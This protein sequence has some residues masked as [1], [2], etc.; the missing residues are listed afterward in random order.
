MKH[1]VLTLVIASFNA[2]NRMDAADFIVPTD[3]QRTGAVGKID[4]L[5][6]PLKRAFA[7]D[8][9]LFA[10]IPAP[11]GND[12]LAQHLEQGQTYD[13]FTTSGP[14]RPTQRRST[15]YFLPVGDFAPETAPSLA[16]LS[17]FASA[18]FGMK[19]SILPFVPVEKVPARTRINSQTK[20]HQILSTDVLAWLLNQIPRD[21]FSVIAITMT[22]LYPKESWNF[23]F[24]QASL[25]DR[26]GVFSFARYD[27]TFYGQARDSGFQQLMLQRSA[28]VLAHETGHMFGIKHCIYFR[29]LMNGANH[30]R[31]D[32]A[33]PLR[34][35]P[36]CLRKLHSSI[37]F[38]IVQRESNLL[39]FF[40]GNSLVEEATWSENRLKQL[41]GPGSK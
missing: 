1:I 17:E 38:D 6:A 34:L 8:V 36:V 19:V 35:C 9:G 31:E 29:C 27:P 11:A 22:D 16:K 26:T 33:C 13:Q 23:V 12:W 3:Q 25:Q 18:F 20:N 30:L 14:P 4:A 37:G 28:K 24:G 7:D 39:N 2:P 5:P 10:P 21:G 40:K 32:D 15:L 41:V